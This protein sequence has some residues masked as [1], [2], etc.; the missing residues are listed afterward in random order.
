MKID[1]RIEILPV[2]ARAG[3]VEQRVVPLVDAPDRDGK[4]KHPAYQ[5]YNARKRLEESEAPHPEEQA[6][7]EAAEE[8]VAK[9]DLRA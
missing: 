1:Q 9:I 8:S 7:V 6:V 3:S 2:P 5:R 4:G